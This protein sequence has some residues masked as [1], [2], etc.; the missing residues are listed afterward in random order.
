[1]LERMC[2]LEKASLQPQAGPAVLNAG[3]VSHLI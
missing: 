1:M 2:V 3:T